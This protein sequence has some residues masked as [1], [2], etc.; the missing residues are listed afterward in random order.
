MKRNKLAGIIVEKGYTQKDI[1]AKIGITPKTF[2]L[3]MKKGV[4]N[5]DEIQKMIVLLDI[6]DAADIFLS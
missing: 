4:W 3:K 1:A 6:K 5:T 2:Y